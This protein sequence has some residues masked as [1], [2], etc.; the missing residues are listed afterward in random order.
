M[1]RATPSE[2]ALRRSLTAGLEQLATTLEDAAVDQL[3]AYLAELER[4]N[5]AYNL[6]GIRD[7]EAMVHRHLLDALSIRPFLEGERIADVGSGAGIPGLPLAVAEPARRF[8]L[9]D[10]GGKKARFLRHAVRTLGLANVE[11]VEARVEAFAPAA[12]LH[13]V[14]ARAFAAPDKLAR[15]ARHLLAPGGRL[16][17]MQGPGSGADVE[18]PGFAGVEEVTLQVPGAEGARKLI[19]ATRTED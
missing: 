8:W 16:L 4:W 10:S 6:S 12:L 18:L 7:P 9:I 19:M 5:R 17:A 13:T 3:L 15:L 1:T 11:V 14:T 2:P